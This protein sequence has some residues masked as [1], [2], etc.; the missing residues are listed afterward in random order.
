MRSTDTELDRQS[1]NKVRGRVAK[2]FHLV[3]D[4]AT[5]CTTI[6]EGYF[7]IL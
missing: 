5:E 6:K 1:F 3:F 2:T 7:D 4:V